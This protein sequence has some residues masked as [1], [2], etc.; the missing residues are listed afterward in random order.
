MYYSQVAYELNLESVELANTLLSDSL[1]SFEAG[2]GSQLDVLEAEAGLA[3]REALRKEA[4]LQR[5][6][7]L[8]N[9]AMFFGGMPKEN[10]IS[11]VATDA[12]V[13]KPVEISFDS[14]ILTA[15]T[16]N[17]DLLNIRLQ[18]AQELIRLGVC[19]KLQTSETVT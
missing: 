6:E 14:S 8:N 4:S 11:Y 19:K 2:R 7:A 12:P 18:M 10:M 3:Q 13:S 1:A 16:M 15:M 9:L 5:I 17:P